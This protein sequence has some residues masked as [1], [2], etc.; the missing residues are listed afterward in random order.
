MNHKD[1]SLYHAYQDIEEACSQSIPDSILKDAKIMYRR[2]NC[3][4]LTRGAIRLG[5]KPIVFY[6][7]VD[8]Q[9]CPERPGN[10]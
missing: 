5:I 2:F 3:E 10:C 4:K 8:W 7:L 6:M 1:E 9:T